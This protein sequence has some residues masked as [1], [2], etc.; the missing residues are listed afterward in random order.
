VDKNLRAFICVAESE[1]LSIAARTLDLTQPSITKRIQNLETELGSALF[2]R[3][4]RGMAL[5]ETGKR[6][7]QHARRIERE[8][9]QAQEEI[10]SRE[11]AGLDVLR[12]GAGPLFHLRY[13]APVFALLNR[14]YALLKLHLSTDTNEANLP[15]LLS[16]QI[17]IMLGVIDVPTQQNGLLAFPMTGV[18]QGIVL[19]DDYL[20]KGSMLSSTKIPDLPWI[21]YSDDKNNENVLR[22]YYTEHDMGSPVV[23]VRTSSFAAGLQL[24]QAG[25]YAMMAPLQLRPVVEAAGLHV[26]SLEPAITQHRAGAY[27]RESSMGFGAVKRFL[28]LL[29]VQVG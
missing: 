15:R 6:F 19:S 13:V 29:E 27:V 17:D 8:F 23:A 25:G 24:V 16:G 21:L 10:R 2:V 12:I 9:L 11:S 5:T 20:P 18:E 3:H 14:E 28:E 1:N 22:R 4:R 26:L 7:L